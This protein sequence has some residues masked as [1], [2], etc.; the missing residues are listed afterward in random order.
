MSQAGLAGALL[1]DCRVVKGPETS[2]NWWIT[3]GRASGTMEVK[4]GIGH[5]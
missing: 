2:V 1:Q 5:V 3:G 4:T